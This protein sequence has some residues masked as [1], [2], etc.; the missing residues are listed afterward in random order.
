MAAIELVHI[1][2]SFG[3]KAVEGLKSAAI[4]LFKDMDWKHLGGSPRP[5][6]A[7]P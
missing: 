5:A 2:K 4:D 3:T 6:P 7:R 1:T